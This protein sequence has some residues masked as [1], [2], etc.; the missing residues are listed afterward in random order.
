MRVLAF[1]VSTSDNGTY[2]VVDERADAIL[3]TL[4]HDDQARS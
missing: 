1:R 2:L 3:I 4:A